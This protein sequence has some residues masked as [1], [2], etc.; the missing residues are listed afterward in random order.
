MHKKIVQLGKN[1]EGRE[2]SLDSVEKL[3][4]LEL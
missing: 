3:N 1:I 4:S 2:S